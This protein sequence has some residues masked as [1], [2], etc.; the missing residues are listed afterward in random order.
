MSLRRVIG[1]LGITTLLIILTGG[2][3]ALAQNSE[4]QY[5]PETGHWVTG[6]F[7]EKY[8][9]VSDPQLLF[10]NPITEAF[11]DQLSGLLVQYFEKVRFEYHPNVPPELRVQTSYLGEY[12]YIPGNPL[13]IPANYPA[14]QRF[15]LTDHQVCYAFLDFFNRNGGVVQFGYPI[16]DFELHEGMIVQYF[17]R[18]RF[19]WHPENSKGNWV[20]LTELGRRYFNLIGEDP[21][22][23]QSSQVGNSPR[24]PIELKVHTFVRYPT[25][26]HSG[27]QQIVYVIVQDHTMEAVSG[28]NVNFILQLPGEKS[29]NYIM[30]NSN[31]HG[32]SVSQP[33][34][35]FTF[36]YGRA[37]ILVTV[38]YRTLTEK[39]R[40][41]FQIWW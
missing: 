27:S 7:L 34:P 38:N 20:V 19:E 1:V 29:V 40:T 33:I 17:Q 39:S 12:L 5:F 41:S 4:G 18:A 16:S 37:D 30:E 11:E 3:K 36:S 8:F 10:G 31:E 32:I 2:G 13:S 35:I 23:L 24:Q 9:S 14:C 6:P 28:A 26:P 21:T 25:V 15:E 22:R